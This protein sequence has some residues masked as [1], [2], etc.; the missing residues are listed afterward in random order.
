MGSFDS[1]RL[2]PHFAQ[3]DTV[4]KASDTFRR[5]ASE[6]PGWRTLALCPGRVP[7]SLKTELLTSSQAHRGVPQMSSPHQPEI[8]RSLHDSVK[9]FFDRVSFYP[10]QPRWCSRCG[11]E[12]QY[13]KALFSLSGTDC[14]WQVLLPVCPCELE[15][16]EGPTTTQ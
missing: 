11:Q 5:K 6:I 13:L 7:A 14:S 12:M 3:D 15:R 4:Q 2:A 10:P 9:S 1:V 8:D 16:N